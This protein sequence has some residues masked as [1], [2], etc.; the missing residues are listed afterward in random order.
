MDKK[1]LEEEKLYLD[2]VLVA[3][4]KKR[5]RNF[6]KIKR[7]SDEIWKLKQYFTDSFYDSN[8]DEYIITN[9]QIEDFENA[10]EKLSTENQRLLKQKKSPYFGRIDFRA[11][12]A[13]NAEKF[14]VG[15]GAIQNESGQNIV[16]D[17]RADVCSLFYDASVGAAAYTC[18]DGVIEGNLSLK[19]QYKIENSKL[20]YYINSNLV[21]DDEILM[22][23]LSRSATN[24][25]HEI[26][27]TIQKEQNLLIRA[28]DFDNTIVQGVAGSGKTSIAMH[29]ISYLLY[30]YRSTLKSEDILILSP[31][32]VFSD[33]LSDVLP[34]LGEEK[35]F[36]TT[37]S[38]MA[39]RML[40]QEFETREQM[41]D[42]LIGQQ[43]QDDFENI[44]IKSS[45]EFLDDLKNFLAKDL[46]KLFLPKS[47]V[48]G[49]V[50][51]SKDELSNLFFVKLAGLEV[52]KRVEA[53][54]E[55]ITDKFSVH[56]VMR[57]DLKRRAQKLL[58]N[59][60]LTTDILKIYN[61]F[62]GSVDLPQVESIG[63][64]DIAPMLLIK[65]N[66][67]GLHTNYDAKYVIV[68]EMQDYSPCHFALF[69]KIWKCGK[70]YLGDVNQSIDRTLP[71]DYLSNLARLTHSKVKF[72][73]KSYRST[74][75]ISLFSQKILGKRIANNVNRSGAQV[76]CVRTT[77]KMQ[78]KRLEKILAE[79]EVH[80]KSVA[81]IC[82]TKAQIM[83]LQ[84][85]SDIIKKFKTLN[86]GKIVGKKIITTPAGAKGVE[87][88][89]VI[90]PFASDENY[91]N[92]LDR[93][94]LYV[95]ATRALHNLFFVSDKTPSRFLMKKKEK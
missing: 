30:K 34:S 18:P 51:I 60:F 53:I 4:D 77:P 17:W 35:S 6:K 85:E 37:F 29:R 1:V 43:R 22:E 90:V 23:Q 70:L 12:D 49:D 24:K 40:G 73:T 48:F 45:F 39:R 8:T 5:D 65:E 56:E 11:A 83:Q 55:Y 88:D 19:R 89:V 63:A 68:D 59:R 78:A 47:M 21:I 15:L 38:V 76:E 33:Y 61:L 54:A 9:R 7:N 81:I 25:M 41:L 95:S 16:Y 94:L 50:A 10:N 44:A 58:Y 66:L 69:D 52:H 3:T 20:S 26:A 28:N 31:S 82:K 87:F 72:L 46:C 64:Y 32:E 62:L 74:K 36:T 67:V 13:A 42:R 57:P 84:K 71:E 93:N 14:Y 27:S 86:G 79:F 91:R 92:G 2:S 80:R 75:E